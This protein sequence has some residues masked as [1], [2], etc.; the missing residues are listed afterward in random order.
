MPAGSTYTPI[1]TT[2]LGSDSA[3]ITFSSIS[4]SYT[5]II[6]VGRMVANTSGNNNVRMR[7][8]GDSNN[9]YS[10]TWLFGDG[11]SAG[12]TRNTNFNG[13]TLSYPNSTDTINPEFIV[14]VQNYSNSTTYK[15]ALVR[16]FWA[17]TNGAASTQVGLWRDTSAINQI[18]F[19]TTNTNLGAG[20]MI[21]LYG[22]AAA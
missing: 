11:S 20:M 13:I 4:S 17:G 21:S 8:N 7:F 9:N 14:Q 19:H 16:N 12:S 2:T 5:D 18:S 1:A 22:I 3:S 6:V 15:T 10:L